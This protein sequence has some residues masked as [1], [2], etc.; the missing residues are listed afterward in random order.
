M[1]VRRELALRAGGFDTRFDEPAMYEDVEFSERLRR[2]GARIWYTGDAVVDHL[3]EQTGRWP[4]N[5]DGMEVVRARHMSLIFRLH[6]PWSWPVMALAYLG[7]A[8]WK[9]VRGRLSIKTIWGVAAAL[10]EGWRR[11]SHPRRELNER[12][13]SA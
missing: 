10:L 11:G 6:R 8:K 9:V 4:E 12:I 1:A 3:V 7:A 13:D 2:L 5:L